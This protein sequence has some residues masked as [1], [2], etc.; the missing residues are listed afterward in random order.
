M[1]KHCFYCKKPIRFWQSKVNMECLNNP[2]I[3]GYAH[4]D[5]FVGLQAEILDELR[6]DFTFLKWIVG[7]KLGI[8]W[9]IKTSCQGS[10]KQDEGGD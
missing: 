4:T 1:S 8:E 6:G 9:D 3:Y 7:K 2:L 10:I 5:C